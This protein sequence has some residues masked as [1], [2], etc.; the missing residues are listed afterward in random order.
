MVSPVYN[1]VP[2][3]VCGL[4]YVNT[5][6]DSCSN[7]NCVNEYLLE[8]FLAQ[9]HPKIY[10]LKGNGVKTLNN[11]T[12]KINKYCYITIIFKKQTYRVGFYIVEDSSWDMLISNTLMD[13]LGMK[14]MIPVDYDEYK[15]NDNGSISIK[16]TT[17]VKQYYNGLSYD[18]PTVSKPTPTISTTQ[19][20]YNNNNIISELTKYIPPKM[21]KKDTLEKKNKLIKLEKLM[22]H[23]PVSVIVNGDAMDSDNDL[24]N[25]NEFPVR[26]M[27]NSVEVNVENNSVLDRFIENK[28][29]E[30]IN[31]RELG[32]PTE[33][34]NNNIVNE[35]YMFSITGKPLP[36][37]D[38]ERTKLIKNNINRIFNDRRSVRAGHSRKFVDGRSRK[39]VRQERKNEPT[40]ISIIECINALIVWWF[41]YLFGYIK[42]L[43]WT[44][45]NKIQN[46]G[47]INM[48][49]GIILL[50]YTLQFGTLD[51]NG[52]NIFGDFVK[53]DT[54]VLK[55]YNLSNIEY[56]KNCEYKLWEKENIISEVDWLMVEQ[57]YTKDKYNIYSKHKYNYCIANAN[58]FLIYNN[59]SFS[60]DLDG[61]KNRKSIS[62][63]QAKS[64]VLKPPL[65]NATPT[66]IDNYKYKNEYDHDY[67]YKISSTKCQLYQM[68]RQSPVAR[69]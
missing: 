36:E 2:L 42:F 27:P 37:I 9:F 63:T 64:G 23:H 15:M 3:F 40:P 18:A 49:Y 50:I 48:I 62:L 61:L 41:G 44:L 22:V 55:N 25:E 14:L 65:R 5:A 43:L 20:K 12:V 58:T 35:N 67:K 60:L 29:N 10:Q 26:Q 4:D 53:G 54:G 66:V 17:M 52:Y 39:G 13:S 46:I 24:L 8:G 21:D 47:L 28:S 57:D 51:H 34:I 31:V 45:G 19:L 56:I 30:I 32:S 6:V 38:P 68:H 69:P 1:I 16:P 11:N 59:Y 33:Q 7:V